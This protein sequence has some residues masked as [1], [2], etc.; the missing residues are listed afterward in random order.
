MLILSTSAEIDSMTNM[1][2]S[3]YLSTV[4]WLKKN[5]HNHNIIWLECISNQEPLYL[6]KQFPCYCSNCHNPNYNNKGSNLGKA[7]EKFFNNNYVDDE[8]TV[9]ITGRYQFADKYFFDIIEQNP[10][11]DLYAKE[12]DNQYF[13][14]CFAIKTNYLI[15][16]LNT[17]DWDFM[18]YNM[19]N[20]EKSLWNFSKNKK[21]KSYH[22]DSIHMDCNVFGNG[23]FVRVV[24]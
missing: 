16:W 14:G 22:V 1:R 24:V 13:T 11:Y 5:I 15:E 21:L 8:L 7:L 18:N 9:Q 20:I 2:H 3:E 19:V 12:I 17:T 23:N 10:G 4:N 6:Q